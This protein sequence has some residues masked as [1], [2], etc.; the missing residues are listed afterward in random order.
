[1]S[2]LNIVVIGLG[3]QSLEDHLPAIEESGYWNLVGVADIDQTIAEETAKKY[4]V[5]YAT[6]VSG[7][8]ELLPK[9]PDA[10][11]IAVPH[12][13]YLPLI[14]TLAAKKINIIKEKPF[15]ISVSEAKEMIKLAQDND[16]SIQV[17]LQR[18]FNPIFQSFNQLIKRIGKIYSIEARYT[19]N[20]ARLDDGWRS[21]KVFAGGGA[22]VDLGYH[23]IDLIVW[24]FGLPDSITCRLSTSNREGQ[25]YDVEDTAVANFTYREDEGDHKAILG[26]LV[27]SRVY[28][29]KD[30]SLIAYGSKGSVYIKRGKVCRRGIDGVEV[31]VLERMGGW[32]SAILDQLD[33]FAKNI[34]AGKNRGSID[35]Q[36]LEHVAFIEAA[37]ESADKHSTVDPRVCLKRLQGD[38]E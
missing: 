36:H 20:I 35:P 25:L 1:M 19:L 22:L 31:E 34:I 2:K 37:Y 9:L 6:K 13:D 17:T 26:T 18:R 21:S 33:E 11:L 7:L 30:E 4:S 15:A 23:Y 12:K 24:Y 27:V 10:A 29:E 14:K 28:P 38:K 5:P 8:L 32:P 3:H 16:V